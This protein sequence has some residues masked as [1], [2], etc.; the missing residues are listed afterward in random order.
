MINYCSHFHS[1]E[2]EGEA[3]RWGCIGGGAQENFKG[4]EGTPYQ[5]SKYVFFGFCVH[6]SPQRVLRSDRS[7]CFTTKGNAE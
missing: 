2:G 6:H 4:A 1:S 5:A 3:P 7:A